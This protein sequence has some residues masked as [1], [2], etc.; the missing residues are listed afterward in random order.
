MFKGIISTSLRF[1]DTNPSG[2]ILN[3]FSKD[4]GIVDEHLPKSLLDAVQSM[5]IITGSVLLTLF[6]RPFFLIPIVL[7]G[8]A[9]FYLM[10]IYLNTSKDIKRMEGISMSHADDQNVIS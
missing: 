8:I 5:L 6:V 2:R 4:L 3:L 9:L 7:I 1:F 10:K